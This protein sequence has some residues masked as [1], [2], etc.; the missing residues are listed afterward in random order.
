MNKHLLSAAALNDEQLLEALIPGNNAI[1]Q[2]MRAQ[3]LSF[4][5]NPA[6]RGALIIGPIGSGKS[7]IARIIALMRY[8]YFCSDER[9]QLVVEGLKFDGPF[10]IDKKLLNWF[11]EINLTGLSVELAHAQLF[12]MAKRAATSVD[13]KPGI[14]EQ[15][16][17]GHSSEDKRSDGARITGGV[18]LL[19]EIGDFSPVLQPL[20]LLLLTNAEVFRLGGEGN[21]KYGYTYRGVTLGATWKDPLKA[22]FNRNLRPDLLSRLA[23]YV[24]RMPGLNERPDEFRNILNAMVEDIMS[25]HSNHLNT[26]ELESPELVSRAKIKNERVRRLSLTEKSITFLQ[27]QDWSQRGDLRGLRQILERSFYEGI[28]P[29]EAFKSAACAE[30]SE[31]D[32]D[33]V[34]RIISDIGNGESPSTLTRELNRLEGQMRSGVAD[35]LRS[36]AA[37]RRHVA[38]RLGIEEQALRRELANLTRERRNRK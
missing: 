10:R 19:D 7:T 32:Y 14:F 24:I 16:M 15:A 8:L 20:L 26:L 18:V 38:E 3:I 27:D 37:V 30:D 13:E 35:R 31:D 17:Y 28:D 23:G 21:A 11:E 22:P 33:L 4:V 25:A 6:A 36:Q 34:G 5:R 9:R 2:E 1:T 12:G 29:I